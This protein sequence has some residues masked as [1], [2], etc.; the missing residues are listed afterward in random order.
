MHALL[1]SL[2]AGEAK[3]ITSGHEIEEAWE[4]WRALCKHYEPVMAV[5]NHQVLKRTAKT[6]EETKKALTPSTNGGGRP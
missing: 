2:T 5:Q 1:R 4:A 6:P 3:K